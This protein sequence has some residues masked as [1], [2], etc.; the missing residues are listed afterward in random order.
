MILNSIEL[1][2]PN[3][4]ATLALGQ[5]LAQSFPGAGAGGAVLYL[6]GELGA[7]KTSCARSLL[8]SLGVAGTI[9]SPTYTLVESYVMPRLTC[10]HVDLYRLQTPLEV[11]ELGLRDE[12]GA[13]SL[14]VVEWPERG[15]TAL[16]PAD[17]EATLSY[18][19]PG[20]RALLAASTELGRRWLQS[21]RDDNRLLPYVSN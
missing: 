6:R 19:E 10:V 7:G 20:R 11:D 12:W 18:A 14:M 9:R 8:R 15:A 16:P 5:L 17:V 2:L 21:L 1:A 13:G 3:E 4:E